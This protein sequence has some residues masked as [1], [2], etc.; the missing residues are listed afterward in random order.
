M[1]ASCPLSWGRN[2]SAEKEERTATTTTMTTARWRGW[3]QSARSRAG[4]E[5][6]AEEEEDAGGLWTSPGQSNGN[7]F[8]VCRSLYVYLFLVPRRSSFFPG[9]RFT[10]LSP[11]DPFEESR[12]SLRRCIT[13]VRAKDRVV[14]RVILFF[15]PSLPREY[16]HGRD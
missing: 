1:R 9:T 11:F 14:L 5:Q 16:F 3:R 8:R 2:R 6:E 4:C 7:F 15:P 13:I 10:L 12:A